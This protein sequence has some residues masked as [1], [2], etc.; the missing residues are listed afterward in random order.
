M[1]WIK[2]RRITSFFFGSY[3]TVDSMSIQSISE[4]ECKEMVES[5][6]CAGNIMEETS[7][8]LFSYKVSPKGEG[9]W[10]R[11]VTYAIKNCVVQQISLK[12]DCLNCPITSPFGVLTNKSDASSVITHDATIIWTNPV[13]EKDEK[14]SLKLVHRGSAVITKM[15]SGIFKLIDDTHQLEFN[16]QPD[17]ISICEHKFHK[18]LNMERAYIQ[19]PEKNNK[20]LTRFFNRKTK[21]CLSYTSNSHEK[22][23]SGLDQKFILQPNLMIST[24]NLSYSPQCFIFIDQAL[25]KFDCAIGKPNVSTLVW[26]PN[27]LQITDGNLC[28]ETK[29]NSRVSANNCV[30]EN[31]SQQW[32]LEAPLFEVN[33]TDEENQSL[34]AQHHQF[35]ADKSVDRANILEKEI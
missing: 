27:T 31:E 4:T 35:I 16:Y 6:D 25:Y 15:D 19:I 3:D 26:N 20:S 12:K 8:N 33:N 17:T 21:T 13:L 7:P 5:H 29:P 2:E 34:L 24:A 28:L 18:L 1:S 10:M 30:P 14:C 32:L 11:V 23:Q 9:S 22:C